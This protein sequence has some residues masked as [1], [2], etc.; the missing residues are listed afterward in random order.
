MTITKKHQLTGHN[1]GIYALCQGT[2]SDTFLSAAGDGWIVEW[3]L[4][5]PETGRLL[6][7]VDA[8]IFSVTYLPETQT[9]VA[10]DMNGGLHWVNLGEDRPNKHIAHHRKGIFGI[11]PV[12]EHLFTVGGD[13][14][15]T[16]WDIQSQRTIE[17]LHLSAH[18]LRSINYQ[19]GMLAIGS[20][21]HYIYVLSASDLVVKQQWSA[22]KN[23]VFALAF[24]PN[25]QYLISGSRD[26]YLKVW[27]WA[28]NT[29]ISEQPAHLYT[30]NDLVF[31]HQYPYFFSA[32]RDRTVKIWDASTFKLLKVLEATRDGGHINSV[33]RLLWMSESQT[34]VSASDDRTLILWDVKFKDK[35]TTST[36][37]S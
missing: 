24:H 5:N 17:S 29:C 4:A 19:D 30:I 18:P 16:R 2:R 35:I 27:D 28:M 20:S 26:A 11:L 7:K 13:G 31:H 15:L 34:L 37:Q 3:D 36:P 1:S 25:S 33:N 22:H 23:S 14:L 12:G 8:Q 21:D 32:S 6:A 9:I 10:G